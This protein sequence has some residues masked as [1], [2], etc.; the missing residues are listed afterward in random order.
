MLVL[1]AIIQSRE[2]KLLTIKKGRVDA[3]NLLGFWSLLKVIG[4]TLI[5]IVG[6]GLFIRMPEMDLF[7]FVFIMWAWA[8][9]KE[10]FDIPV[11]ILWLTGK[12][13]KIKFKRR[14]RKL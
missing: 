9:F 4:D 5:V 6:G 12:L 13:Q 2:M 1:P 14:K 8:V 10:F 7:S 3:R 11:T